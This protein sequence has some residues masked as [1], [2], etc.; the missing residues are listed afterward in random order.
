MARN[1]TFMNPSPSASLSQYLS[2][3][4]G[5]GHFSNPTAYVSTGADCVSVADL[6]GIRALLPQVAA[7][8][9]QIK[10]SGRLRQRIELLARFLEETPPAAHTLA[11][12]EAAF[13]LYYFLKGFDLIP[14]AIPEIGLMDDALLVETALNRN[15][16]DMRT[17]W[18]AQ[19]RTWPDKL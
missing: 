15:L 8:A 10:D 12:R 14:D 16:H 18:T 4:A 1:A 2:Q 6:E 11:Q 17:H 19:G 7:K 13:V 3:M 5:S 9:A